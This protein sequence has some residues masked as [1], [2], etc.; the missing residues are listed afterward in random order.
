MST[1]RTMSLSVAFAGI[2]A[3]TTTALAAPPF[4]IDDVSNELYSWAEASDFPLAIDDWDTNDDASFWFANPGLDTDAAAHANG[5]WGIGHSHCFAVE[6]EN[7]FQLF[8]DS[9]GYF[10]TGDEQWAKGTGE[11]MTKVAFSLTAPTKVCGQFCVRGDGSGGSALAEVGL[12]PIDAPSELVVFIT[13]EDGQGCRDFE[14]VLPSGQYV[15]RAVSNSMADSA[16]A[17]APDKNSWSQFGAEVVFKE[18]ADPDINDDGVVDGVDLARMLAQWG[19]DN[20]DFDF[21]GDGV[22]DGQDLALLLAAWG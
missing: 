5:A 4:A 16:I 18:I 20:P 14:V 1:T 3:S 9:N 8:G 2:L 15:V 13:L 19:S 21:N 17:M 12:Y 10:T 11:A 7:G 22:V 6:E